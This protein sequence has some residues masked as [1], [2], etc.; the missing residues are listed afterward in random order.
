MK[1]HLKVLSLACLAVAAMACGS[2]S[3][4]VTL[5][6]GDSRAAGTAIMG[7]GVSSSESTTLNVGSDSSGI[8]SST[9]LESERARGLVNFIAKRAVDRAMALSNPL[10]KT[11]TANDDYTSFTFTDEQV[12]NPAGGHATI[13]GVLN[14]TVEDTGTSF[15]LSFDGDLDAVLSDWLSSV[16][17][18]GET[19]NETVNGTLTMVFGGFVNVEVE[20]DNIVATADISSTVTSSDMDIAGTVN[21][22]GRLTM[23]VTIAGD[24]TSEGGLSSGCSGTATVVTSDHGTESCAVSA[25][26]SGC[27]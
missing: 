23:A 8:A 7:S 22:S 25:D 4:D 13:N 10:A 1:R 15:K 24:A 11:V 27:N 26:C 20:G 6:S 16:L 21:G 5:A 9:G 19:Y 14:D 17:L 2:S 12:A 3:N 18:D